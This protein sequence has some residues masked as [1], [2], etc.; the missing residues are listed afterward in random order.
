MGMGRED[1]KK[2]QMWT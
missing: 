1:V 2:N